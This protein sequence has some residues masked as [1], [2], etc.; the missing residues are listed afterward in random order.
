MEWVES[1]EVHYSRVPQSRSTA[2]PGADLDDVGNP[3]THKL[4][5]PARDCWSVGDLLNSAE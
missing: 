1:G 2:D 3:A 5:S 4:E